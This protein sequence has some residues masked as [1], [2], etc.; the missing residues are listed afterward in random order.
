M[1]VI[2]ALGRQKNCGFDASL[3][4]IAKLY[5]KTKNQKQTLTN[6]REMRW[7]FV[8]VFGFWFFET[9]FLCIALA[10]LELTL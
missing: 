5:L 3:D 1:T 9:G 4:Y 2:S 7:I 6:T 10:V 8:L